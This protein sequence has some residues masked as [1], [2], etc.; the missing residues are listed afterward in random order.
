VNDQVHNPVLLSEVIEILSPQ[1]GDRYLDLTAGFGGHASAVAQLV[2]ARGKL[3][4]VDRD[5]DAI[6]TLDRVFGTDSRVQILQDDFFGAS[7]K[8]LAKG[9]KFDLILADLGVSS[10]QLDVSQRGFSF[11]RDELLDMRMDESQ[12]KSAYDV[13]NNYEAGRLKS[14]L[15]GYGELSSKQATVLAKK[16]VSNRPI[17]STKELALLVAS[18]PHNP[19]KKLQPQV[20]QA[21]RIEVNDELGL[22][23]KA[24]PV[25]MRL[26]TSGGR[27][28][29]ISFHS[30]EDRIVK[31]FFVQKSENRYDAKIRLVN[32]K[33]ITAKKNELVYNPRA[34]SA[35]LRAAVKK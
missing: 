18:I 23:K 22:L 14:V 25:W 10:Y 15:T 12:Q 3:T 33:P 4:L 21:I 26:L 29:V 19:R 35:K 24:L 1:K 30:L 31:Q 13:V 27:L 32:K 16:I 20:F 2:G 6:N 8:L 7:S 28:I 5:K 17:T 9:E 11:N 34:R